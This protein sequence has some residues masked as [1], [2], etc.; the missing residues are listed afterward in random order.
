MAVTTVRELAEQTK[1]PVERLLA[2]LGDAGVNVADADAPISADEKKQWLEHL[3]GKPKKGSLGLG[4]SKK[5][6][7]KRKEQ[8]ELK[9]AGAR[10]ARAKTINVEVRKKL[11]SRSKK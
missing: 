3:Q 8:T 9:V 4:G 10:G 7:L 1:M 11:M 2:Q 5:I 6:S